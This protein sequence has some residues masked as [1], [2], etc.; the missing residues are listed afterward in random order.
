MISLQQL[1]TVPAF[2]GLD[3]DQLAAIQKC[4]AEATFNR[5]ERLFAEGDQADHLWV[6]IDGKVDLRF[7]LPGNPPS[8]KDTTITSVDCDDSEKTTLGW[9]CF[10]PPY[11]MMLSA[12]CVSRTST[13]IKIPKEALL[14]LFDND[15]S[16]GYHVMSHLLKVLGYRFIQFQEELAK[17]KGLDIMNAW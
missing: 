8:T 6:I 16:M 5:N 3:D 9:S 2:K 1:E 14:A 4:C 7:E 12:Y 15:T 13:V 10:V 11:R 17:H